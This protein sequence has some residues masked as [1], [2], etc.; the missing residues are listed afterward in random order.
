M[1]SFVLKKSD[2]TKA[3]IT[4]N[5]SNL[6]G[7]RTIRFPINPKWILFTSFVRIH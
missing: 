7:S 5:V 4:N 1:N 3:M 6:V 2:I